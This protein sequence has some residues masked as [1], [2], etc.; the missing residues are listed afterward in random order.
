MAD[1]VMRGHLPKLPKRVEEAPDVDV[2]LYLY[3]Q[4]YSELTTCRPPATLGGCNSIPWTA[5]AE[6]ARF[7]SFD[8]D[9]FSDLV[10]FVRELDTE[11]AK[12]YDRQTSK[13]P[14]G[15]GA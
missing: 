6:Y 13:T 7:H 10:Y 3:W 5:C 9:Q 14:V 11:F 12:W 8:Y 2:G 4:A 1:A 15:K